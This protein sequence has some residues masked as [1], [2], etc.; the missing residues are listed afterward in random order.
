[1]IISRKF[2]KKYREQGE[3]EGNLDDHCSLYF[4]SKYWKEKSSAFSLKKG[5]TGR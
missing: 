5:E 3:D 2:Q 4:G 1:M